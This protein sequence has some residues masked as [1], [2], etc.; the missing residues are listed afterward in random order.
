LEDLIVTPKNLL[1][2]MRASDV[3]IHILSHSNTRFLETVD[4]KRVA[5]YN[6]AMEPYRDEY[7][8]KRWNGTI[9]PT[10]AHAQEAG[11]S[12]GEY[13]DFVY[14]SVLR[15]WPSEIARMKP[16]KEKM[17]KAG[18]VRLIGTDTDLSFSIK[19]RIAV[20]DDAKLNMPGGE[21]YTAPV[22][23]SATGKIL[24][25]LPSIYAGKEVTGIRLRFEK[26]M[27][28]DYSA[29]KNESLLKELIATDEGSKRLGEFGVGTNRGIT[30]STKTILFDEKIAGTIH[31]AI[32][33]AYKQCGGINKSA[34]HWDMIK[35][36]KPG[37][38]LMDDESVQKDGKFSWE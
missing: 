3:D 37:E 9:H 6:K 14:S 25:D 15:D 36:M 38:I 17:D 2:A 8:K 23:D 31:L 19:G 24:F 7:L 5:I 20:V 4:S 27:I 35:T 32:G 26:G 22:D 30:R 1:E 34:V 29:S 21:L 33:N 10:N 16:L 13:R 11:M 18:E 28:V 12:L